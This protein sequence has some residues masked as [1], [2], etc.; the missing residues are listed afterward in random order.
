MELTNLLAGFK[1]SASGLKVQ[2]VKMNIVADNIA[3]AET[4]RT[5]EGGPYQKKVVVLQ[6]GKPPPR[7]FLTLLSGKL[8]VNPQNDL[9]RGVEV[10]QVKKVPGQ[11]RL[12]YDPD[13]P[14][15]DQKG[16]VS[17]PDI[18]IISEMVNLITVSR[19]YEANITVMNAS[20]NIALRAL[21]I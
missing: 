20:K 14:D 18:D 7:T 3:N 19:A 17:Y 5:K 4:T 6:E 16:Y 10:Y 2:Q 1:I 15:A 11:P 21:E 9:F 12:V 8:S 13:H